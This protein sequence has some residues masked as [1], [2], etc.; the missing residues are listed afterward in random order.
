MKFKENEELSINGTVHTIKVINSNSFEISDTTGFLPFEGEGTARNIKTPTKL[1]FKS[2][3]ES[4]NLQKF[5]ENLLYYDWAKSSKLKLLHTAFIA[6]GDF[7]KEHHRQPLSW[8]KEDA[9][10][11]V[12]FVKK[13]REQLSAE[14]EQYLK[15]FAFTCSGT[16]GSIAALFGGIAAQEAFK[17]ITGKYTPINQYFLA[18]F[19]QIIETPPEE[20]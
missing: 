6:L 1:S 13:R 7:T 4:A 20:E 5:D 9:S 18:E 15:L 17:A 16:F 2:L 12:E 11:F 19:S 14:D 10:A 3:E 8:N